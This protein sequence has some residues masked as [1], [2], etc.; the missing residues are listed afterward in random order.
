MGQN[1]VSHPQFERAEK[2]TTS[3]NCCGFLASGG[4]EAVRLSHAS[5]LSTKLRPKKYGAGAA[6]IVSWIYIPLEL[7]TYILD[8]INW[9][10]TC[11]K[12]GPT[13]ARILRLVSTRINHTISKT[14]VSVSRRM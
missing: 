2:F 3:N 14:S 4:K 10:S 12:F 8:K 13:L 5:K 11:P 1:P 7:S 6:K 9:K